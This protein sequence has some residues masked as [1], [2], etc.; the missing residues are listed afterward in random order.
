M[1]IRKATKKD[2]KRINDLKKETFKKINSKDYPKKVVDDYIKKQSTKKIISN[3]N[4][5]PYF[6]LVENNRILGSVHLYNKN[7]IGGLYVKYNKIGRGYGKM[8]MEFIENFAKKKGIK[9]VILYPTKTAKNFYKKLGYREFGKKE[10][11]K[12]AGYNVGEKCME[13]R[14]KWYP[15]NQ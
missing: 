11:I 7:T 12:I 14:L 5:G 4:M 3:M 10:N 13:K 15:K 6:V 1:K 2:A 9:K 8:L